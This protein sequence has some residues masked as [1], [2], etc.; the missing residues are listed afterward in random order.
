M[1]VLRNIRASLKSNVSAQRVRA[2]VTFV[3]SMVL[4]GFGLTFL[5]HAAQ[6]D[7]IYY[8]EGGRGD[9]VDGS[10]DS[11]GPARDRWGAIA[12]SPTTLKSDA[13]YGYSSRR[14][15]ECTVLAACTRLSGTNDWRIAMWVQN[16][17]HALATSPAE[18][19]Y[20]SASG[21]SHGIARQA[22]V[23]QCRLGG[24]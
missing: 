13:S 2:P 1:L 5:P 7:C 15:A 10:S 8:A 17:C 3:F 18:K 6:A 14:Q 19:A 22:A 4:G 12:V 24:G 9:W 23:D 20:G 21:T 16:K 11:N